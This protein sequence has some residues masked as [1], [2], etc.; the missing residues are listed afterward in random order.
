MFMKEVPVLRVIQVA[1]NILVFPTMLTFFHNFTVIN[2]K[3]LTD[4]RT[5]DA[6]IIIYNISSPQVS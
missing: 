4:G 3:M 6:Y 2:R 1:S 5:P